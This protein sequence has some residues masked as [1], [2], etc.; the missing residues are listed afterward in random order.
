[1]TTTKLEGLRPSLYLYFSMNIMKKKYLYIVLLILSL[2]QL[3]LAIFDMSIPIVGAV[4]PLILV[5]LL[6]FDKENKNKHDR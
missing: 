2:I 5:W 6:I 1:M 3:V 4:L